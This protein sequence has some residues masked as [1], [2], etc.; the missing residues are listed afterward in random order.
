MWELLTLGLNFQHPSKVSRLSRQRVLGRLDFVSS[1]LSTRGRNFRRPLEVSA[2]FRP[3]VLR[4]R[5]LLS[6]ELP[7]ITWSI[8]THWTASQNPNL[9]FQ[10][11]PMPPPLS[12]QSLTRKSSFNCG[13][14]LLWISLDSPLFGTSNPHYF[15]FDSR[16]K[17]SRYF[18]QN[19]HRL[20]SQCRRKLMISFW[21]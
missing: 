13:I 17:S 12:S 18:I 2:F 16:G 4:S 14:L 8:Y 21:G 15:F 1:E 9:L 11:P 5:I 7:T 19:P 20:V 10:T 6:S 3:R